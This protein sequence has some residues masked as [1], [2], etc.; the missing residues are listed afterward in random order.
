[1]Q[2]SWLNNKAG[3]IKS[4]EDKTDRKKSYAALKI[5]YG[6]R[7]AKAN[8]LLSANGSK[9]P[10]DKDDAEYFHNVLNSLPFIIQYAINRL[11]Q[12]ECNTQLD[13]FSIVDEM[14][15]AVKQLL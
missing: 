4:F 3:E 14:I 10:T 15:K 12:I 13:E 6:S 5:V 2:D 1:M 8:P 9:L 7:S 11:P